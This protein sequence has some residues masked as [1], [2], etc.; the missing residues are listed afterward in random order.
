VEPEE[1]TRAIA[2]PALSVGVS[3]QL[4]LISAMINETQVTPACYV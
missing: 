2:M 4:A 3:V 1:L